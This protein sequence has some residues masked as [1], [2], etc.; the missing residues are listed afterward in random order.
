MYQRN[1]LKKIQKEADIFCRLQ[2]LDE[3]SAFLSVPKKEIVLLAFDPIYYHFSVAKP[4]GKLRQIEAPEASLKKMQRL[5]NEH[6]QQVY[7]LNQSDA[8]YGYIPTVK[9]GTNPKN[10]RTHAEKHLGCNYMMNADFQDFFHQIS[11]SAVKSIFS[12]PPFSFDKY[13][14]HTLAKICCYKERLPMGAPTSPVLSNFYTLPFDRE[15]QSWA[16]KHNMVYTRFVDDLS[17]SSKHHAITP[18]HF[19]EVT[20]IAEKHQLSFNPSK[21]KYY[22]KQDEKVIT[23]LVLRDTVDIVPD[24]Y[25]ELE[26]DLQRLQAVNEVVFITGKLGTPPMLNTFKQEIM[27]KIAFIAQIEGNNSNEYLQYLNMFYDAENPPEELSVRWTKFGNY[28][29]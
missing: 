13:T 18:L 12:A 9:G 3:V 25:S 4:N 20:R 24:F 28:L 2:T 14:A 22:G 11:L 8:A 15:L 26:K 23:G 5:L 1:L 21:T 6:L 29:T 7:Y 10:I 19:S 17:F 27:G 16:C